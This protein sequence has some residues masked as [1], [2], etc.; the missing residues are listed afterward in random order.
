[1]I[2]RYL[3]PAIV[4]SVIVLIL[5]LIPGEKLPD[6]PIFGIDK[7]VHF[8]IFG[9]LMILT[10]FGLYKISRQA[11]S[12]QNPILISL[13]YSTL[14]GIMIEVIQP[15][16]PNRSFSVYDIIANVIGVGLG[17]VAFNIWKRRQE[18]KS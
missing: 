1:M 12:I 18:R 14:F 9:L 16:V 8:F 17:Y 4:W 5:T 13:L 10:A 6:V 15:Y 2:L 11:N 3:W 7:V